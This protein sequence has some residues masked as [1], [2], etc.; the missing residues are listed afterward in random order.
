[1]DAEAAAVG[2]SVPR[3]PKADATGVTRAVPLSGD[4]GLRP[5]GD[6]WATVGYYSVRPSVLREAA[7]ARND[8]LPALRAFFGRLLDRGYRLD[9]VP[10]ACAIDVDRPPDVKAAEAFLKQA[11]A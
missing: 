9:G 7:A 8:R 3:M 6:V 1:V 4:T 2:R 5:G 11:G 10:V